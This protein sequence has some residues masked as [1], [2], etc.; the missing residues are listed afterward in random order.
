MLDASRLNKAVPTAIISS[1]VSVT[2]MN[3]PDA[4]LSSPEFCRESDLDCVEVSEV[5]D[6]EAGDEGCDEVVEAEKD[7]EA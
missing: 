3:G 4:R 5:G 1:G 6:V 2:S 7:D